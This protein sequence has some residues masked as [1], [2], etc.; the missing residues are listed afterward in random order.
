[1]KQMKKTIIKV[2]DMIGQ[3]LSHIPFTI[4]FINASSILN[5]IYTGYIRH[6]FKKI[7]NSVI[8]YKPLFLYGC[9]NIEIGNN[10]TLEK[11]LQ[12]TSWGGRIHIG[13]RCLIRRGA[14]ISAAN[15]IIIG[16]NLLTG[17][18]ILIT[19]NSHGD[20]D[21]KTLNIPPVERPIFSKGHVKIGNNVW[22]GNNVCIM[23]N[24]TIGD[25]VVIGANS[26]VTHNI[27]SY[28]IAAG[29]PARIIKISKTK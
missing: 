25:C 1:M 12:L 28:A 7:G 13:N 5:R 17:T 14:H 2:L 24:V 8:S 19:D 18:N 22:L 23:S 6:K 27:P 29:I 4:S 9:K 3:L 26:V 20:T 16:D 21:N 15:S 11:D 10:T